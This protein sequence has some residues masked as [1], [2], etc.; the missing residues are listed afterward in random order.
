MPKATKNSQPKLDWPILFIILAIFLLLLQG[1]TVVT[2]VE[3]LLSAAQTEPRLVELMQRWQI[4]EELLAKG[5]RA[6]A[7]LWLALAIW[8]ILGIMYWKDKKSIKHLVIPSILAIILGRW[9]A[10]IFGIVGSW[11]YKKKIH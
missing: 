6:M 2:S 1:I 7:F 11:L 9:G 10:G 3:D 8:L 5:L 4:Q